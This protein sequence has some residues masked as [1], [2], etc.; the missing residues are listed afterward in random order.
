MDN[1]IPCEICNAMVPFESYIPHIDECTSRGSSYT[2][3]RIN[4]QNV[5]S[6]VNAL[7]SISSAMGQ[8][9]S[10]S[11]GSYE[12][13]L[14][15]QELLG[16]NVRVGI[17]NKEEVTSIVTEVAE[18]EGCSICLENLLAAS[19]NGVVI[20]STKCHHMFCQPCIFKWLDEN[21]VCPN[22]T[23]SLTSN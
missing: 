6:L 20:R 22:C 7:N 3:V 10:G 9:G 17:E 23:Q 12:Q 4:P 19:K 2:V 5:M 21:Q 18:E 13:N 14:A 11:A 16:G 8:A 1:Y 15:L